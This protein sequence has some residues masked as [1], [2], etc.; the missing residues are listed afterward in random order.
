M[1]TYK[2]NN[3]YFTLVD[4]FKILYWDKPKKSAPYKN[5]ISGGF[6]AYY[7]EPVNGRTV[8][9]TM[10][11]A[12]LC[13]DI[14]NSSFGIKYLNEWT[15]KKGIVNGK[16]KIT[17]NQNANAQFKNKN[18]ST[19]VVTSSKAYIKAINTLPTDCKYAISGVPV[20]ENGKDVSWRNYASKQGFTSGN[21]YATYRN[22]L[23]IKNGEIVI[24]SG[25]TSTGNYLSTSE[26][27][28]KVRGEGISDL[29]A[30]DGGGSF[31][32]KQ[33]NRNILST[34]ENRQVNNIIVFN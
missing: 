1:K 18:I 20:I 5:Y 12:N 2:K 33:N 14:D 27:F 8:R 4:D 21:M 22:W 23:G 32:L 25:R 16:L 11:V 34:L 9:F 31:I 15:K 13:C 3:L 28:N 19:L 24:I 29:I 17:G 6:F 26:I 7:S 10:P 30:L